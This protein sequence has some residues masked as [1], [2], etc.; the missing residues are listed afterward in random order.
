[1][2]KIMDFLIEQ[3]QQKLKYTSLTLVRSILDDINWEA[4]LIGI[5]GARGIGKLGISLL[6]DIKLNL[7]GSLN[8]TLYV[9]LDDIWFNNNSLVS[10]VRTFEREGG[11]YLFLDEVHK[12]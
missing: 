11:K 4:K 3:F 6:Q 10:L 7:S 9:S 12:Y 5:K 8:Q 2:S 1:M